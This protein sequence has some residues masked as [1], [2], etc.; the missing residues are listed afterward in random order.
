MTGGYGDAPNPRTDWSR[1]QREAEALG[2]ITQTGRLGRS[3]RPTAKGSPVAE[4][5]GTPKVTGAA[6]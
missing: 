6:A 3:V 2:W 1:I 4:W 5:I